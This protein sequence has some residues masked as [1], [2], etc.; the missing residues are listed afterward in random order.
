MCQNSCFY[1]EKK[2]KESG[3]RTFKSILQKEFTPDT[4][5]I[6]LQDFVNKL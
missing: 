4:Y 2:S 3:V 6:L 1:F 5:K